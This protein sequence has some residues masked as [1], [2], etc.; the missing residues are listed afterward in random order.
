MAR[1]PAPTGARKIDPPQPRPSIHAALGLPGVTSWT[2]NT[3]PDLSAGELLAV[4]FYNGA[5]EDDLAR[6][7]MNHL[8]AD[9]AVLHE[10]L[11]ADMPHDESTVLAFVNRASAMALVAAELQRRQTA[12]ARST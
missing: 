6:S 2:V 1:V 8:V 10:A 7:L 12:A 4:I 9:L 3:L 11:C 5:G